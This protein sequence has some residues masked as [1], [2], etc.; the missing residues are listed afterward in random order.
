ME[1]INPNQQAPLVV[2]MCVRAIEARA[3]QTSEFNDHLIRTNLFDYVR[4]RKMATSARG[5]D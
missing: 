3:K 4:Q 5:M 2:D 1:D